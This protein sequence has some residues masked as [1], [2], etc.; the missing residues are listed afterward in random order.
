MLAR[1]PTLF[2][3]RGAAGAGRRGASPDVQTQDHESTAGAKLAHPGEARAEMPSAEELGQRL[4]RRYQRQQQR[5][6]IAPY[7]PRGRGRAEADLADELDRLL[8][9]D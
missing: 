1:P 9:H 8:T 2:L 6:E 4:K 5:Q 3:A 7:G